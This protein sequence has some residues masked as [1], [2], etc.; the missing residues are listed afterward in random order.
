MS[1]IES[2]PKGWSKKELH[3]ITDLQVGYA[4]KSSWFRDSGVKLLRGENVGYGRP[5]WSNTQC[6]VEKEA[7]KFR[8]YVLHDGDIVIGMD[9]T[10]TKSG[11]KISRVSSGDCP[12]LLVQRVGRFVPKSVSND[13]LWALLSSSSFTNALL[14]EQKGMDIPHLSRSEIT[15]PTVAIPDDPEEQKAIARVLSDVDALIDSL[16]ALIDKKRNLKMATMQQLLTG[17][18]RLP[19][20]TANWSTTTFGEAFEHLRTG[21]NSRSQLNSSDGVGYIHYGD[22][23]QKWARYL[24]LSSATLPTIIPEL[25]TGLPRLRDGDLILADASEDYEGIGSGVEIRNVGDREIVSGLHTFALRAK[26]GYFSDGFKGLI[27]AFR[28]VKR[29]M[30]SVATG[31]SVYGISK[32]NLDRVEIPYPDPK[33]QSAIAEILSDMDA[34]IHAL[35][36]RRNKTELMKTGLMQELL[37]GRRRLV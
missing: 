35:V 8:E 12:S 14:L 2:L 15:S 19:G 3:E 37:S 31:I 29:Q 30:E 34:E 16:D 36:A 20:F 10:F 28:S 11:T 23:H 24:D 21:S 4:F 32:K 26:P 17:K 18:K 22:I 5:D 13:F 9:R 1:T 25:V 33:E 27:T 7:F 6:L